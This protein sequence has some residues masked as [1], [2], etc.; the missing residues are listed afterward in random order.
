LPNQR[1]EVESL[2][3]LRSVSSVGFIAGGVLASAGL[4]HRSHEQLAAAS[5]GQSATAF[6]AR[7][8]SRHWCVGSF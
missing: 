7:V 5:H 2:D 4:V 8:E 1:S 3:T 6:A